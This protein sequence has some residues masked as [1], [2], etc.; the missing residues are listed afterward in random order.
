MVLIERE[1]NVQM[2]SV[3]DRRLNIG[4]ELVFSG[5]SINHLGSFREVAYETLRFLA[6]SC[7]LKLPPEK[8]RR[9]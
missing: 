6:I 9:R 5:S 1:Q 3:S 2:L 7:A 4:C 8:Q